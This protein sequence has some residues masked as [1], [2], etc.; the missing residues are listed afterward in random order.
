MRDDRAE[1]GGEGRRR[2]EK[3]GEGRRRPER[4]TLVDLRPHNAGFLYGD[5][6]SLIELVIYGVFIR[7]FFTRD[8][9]LIGKI[10]KIR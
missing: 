5:F 3:A 9:S 6:W 1:K 10:F 2:P 8:A 7:E 4:N